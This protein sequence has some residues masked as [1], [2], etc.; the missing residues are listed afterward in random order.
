MAK[1]A[2]TYEE[3]MRD[4]AQRHFKPVYFLMGEESFYID[5]IVE[6][7]ERNALATEE[8]GFNLQVF[9]GMDAD[10]GSVINSAKSYPMGAEH[11]VV[12]LREAQHM[13]SLDDLTFYLQNPQPTTILVITYKNGSVDRRKKF[14]TTIASIGVLFE[15]AKVRENQLPALVTSYAREHG[16]V[17]DNKSS[18][19]I[20]ESVGN[21]LSR[22]YGELDKLFVAM[23]SM[24]TRNISSEIVE[25][26]IGISKDFNYFELQNAL[27]NKDVFKAN[28][29]VKYFDKNQKAKPIQV[30]LPI[31]FRFFSSLMV[32][33]YAPD[34]S[35]RGLA[36][37]LGM[38]DWQV[39]YNILPAMKHYSARK[40]LEILEEIRATD[41]KSKGIG[42]SKYNPGELLK[43]LIF[44]ILH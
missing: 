4:I 5:R 18:V 32:A 19:M 40:V 35:E 31:L 29:I 24:N 11:S 34:R 1:K 30:T 27:I 13:K 21:D 15:S 44:F 28:Q 33:Y 22:L 42:G 7:I 37:Y 43:Q 3:I 38:A 14:A 17:V 16:Y 23:S 20:A 9:Y 41:E 25:R 10:L 12:E 8:R 26:H 36:S 2:W 6:S 39:R